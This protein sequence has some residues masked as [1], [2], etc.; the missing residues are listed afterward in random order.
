MTE[1][2]KLDVYKFRIDV[3]EEDANTCTGVLPVILY[4]AGYCCY[5]VFKKMK[6]N[7]CKDLIS[8]RDC[9]DPTKKVNKS[10]H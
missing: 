9:R 5:T 6:C 8:G 3:E 4:L 1:E 10:D 2:Q 7:S